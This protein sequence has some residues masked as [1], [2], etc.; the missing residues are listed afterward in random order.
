MEDTY[1]KNK[2]RN[3]AF[4]KQAYEALE[5]VVKRHDSNYRKNGYSL[6][7]M[8]YRGFSAFIFDA[9][10]D[11]QKGLKLLDQVYYEWTWQ[12]EWEYT[13]LDDGSKRKERD[14]Y[15]VRILYNEDESLEI[16]SAR[17]DKDNYLR[18]NTAIPELSRTIMTPVKSK[19]YPKS[20]WFQKK[21]LWDALADA[22]DN[23][24]IERSSYAVIEKTIEPSIE[25]GDDKRLEDP[26]GDP[27]W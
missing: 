10:P 23:P 12:G 27:D 21:V 18:E 4:L 20:Q 6:P 11:I 7:G 5:I 16:L 25:W 3:E 22:F 15:I 14:Q 8:I 13:T 26:Y 9:E 24:I 2:E 1:R 17:G 19:T